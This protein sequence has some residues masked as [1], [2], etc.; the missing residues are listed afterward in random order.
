MLLAIGLGHQHTHVAPITSSALSEEP[1]AGWI[2]HLGIGAVRDGEVTPSTDGITAR[3]LRLRV[4]LVR[5]LCVLRDLDDA[6]KMGSLS[7]G[8]PTERFI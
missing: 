7:S 6:H 5:R 4:T 8:P 2:E 3:S 1:L